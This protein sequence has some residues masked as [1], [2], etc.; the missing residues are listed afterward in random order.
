MLGVEDD[1]TITGCGKFDLQNIIESIYDRTVPNLF[2]RVE[3]QNIEDK[4]VIIIYVDKSKRLCG[5]SSGE[6][7]KRLGKNSKPYTP[8]KM[9]DVFDE[10]TDYSSKIIDLTSEDDINLLEVYKL[11]EKLKTRDRESTLVELDDMS[12]LKNLSLIKETDEGIKLTVAGL[13]RIIYSELNA[14]S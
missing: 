4:N 6:Y 5:T 9:K 3:S 1:G 13:L 10:D 2:T 7:Y 8:E 12:F 14:T 11:K